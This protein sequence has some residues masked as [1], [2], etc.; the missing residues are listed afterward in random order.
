MLRVLVLVL[1]L[2]RVRRRRRRRRGVVCARVAVRVRRCRHG[3][4]RP[5]VGLVV[6][7]RRVRRRRR[8]LVLVHGLLLD[9]RR[10]RLRHD[11][12]AGRHGGP[13]QRGC[14]GARVA[15][16]RLRIQALGRDEV[17]QLRVSR[18]LR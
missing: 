14:R 4:E 2:G 6:L 16:A 13:R 12:L 1:V 10:L 3:R 11:V 18:G 8:V 7:R 5:R 15:P 17:A 9:G